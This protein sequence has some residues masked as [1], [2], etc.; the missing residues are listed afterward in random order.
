[1]PHGPGLAGTRQDSPD[2]ANDL[3]SAIRTI[4]RRHDPELPVME[5]RTIEEQVDRLLEAER[6]VASLS[7]AFALL[8]IGI[9]A[10]GLYGVMSFSVARRT[11]EIGIRMALGAAHAALIRMVLRE[12]AAM[13]AVGIVAGVSVALLLRRYVESALYGIPVRDLVSV[14][15]AAGVLAAVTF[16]SGWLPARRASRVDPV[17]ALRQE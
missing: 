3:G 16:V 1:M 4:V 8:A 11:R 15:A 9:A 5:Y 13:T 17:T 2:R 10:V 14:T 7:T 6:L 12:V